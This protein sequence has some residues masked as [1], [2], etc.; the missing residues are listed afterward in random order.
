MLMNRSAIEKGLFRAQALKK[1]FETIKKNPASSQTG[2]FMKPDI[3]KV[4]IPKD[5]NYNKLSEEGYA[6]PETYIQDGDVIIGMVNPK[7]VSREDEKPYKD[8][9]TIYRSL[10]P[11]AI[12][13]VFTGLNSDGYPIIKIRV[14]SERIPQEGDK[15]SCYDD[16]TEVLTDKGW[17]Y[18]KDLTKI[19]KVATLINGKTL[20]YENPEK[21]QKYKYD[22]DMY[23]IKT[24]QVDLC[25]TPN[26][27]MWV[28]PRGTKTEIK[29]YKL[30]RADE[31]FNKRRFYQ[32]NVTSWDPQIKQD[33]FT[34]PAYKDMPERNIEMQTWCTFLGIWI[35]EGHIKDNYAVC[36]SAHKERVKNYLNVVCD[37][38]KLSISKYRDHKDASQRN[39]W[40]IKDKQI[41]NYLSKYDVGAV[42]KYLPKF[43]WNLSMKQCQYLIHGMMLGDGHW[44]KNGTMRYDTS[45]EQLADDLQRLCLHAGWSANK[46]LKSEKGAYGGCID[47]RQIISTT[48]GYRLTIVTKQNNPKVNKNKHCDEYVPYNGHVYCCTVSSGVIYVRRNGIPVFSGNSR[49]GSLEPESETTLW[50]V[51]KQ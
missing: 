46:I 40:L 1:Y 47:G 29:N 31:I 43:V 14:R 48:E 4:D 51:Y 34:L 16:K 6:K 37:L 39:I 24:N 41:I 26:H 27:K 13:R 44:M 35:A 7:P 15:F 36:F 38:M 49:A 5:A 32:K 10:V 50:L 3:S 33:F 21:I 17:I 18:F 19:H 42:N 30:E 25:V 8:N 22:N 9:S 20:V 45:S 2:I 28:A 11:G 12:D 23:K